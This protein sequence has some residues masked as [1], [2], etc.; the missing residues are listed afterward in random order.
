EV[1]ASAGAHRLAGVFSPIIPRNST[2][3]VSRTEIYAT[4]SDGQRGVDI[5]VY[6]GES[7]LGRDNVYPD[8]Y[9]GAGVPPGAAGAEKVAVTFTYDINGILKVST[10]VVS[11]GKEAHLLVDKS[12]ARL[13]DD[14]RAAAKARLD[15]EWGTSAAA[16]PAPP[17]PAAAAP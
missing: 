1:Q 6:Q 15:R 16:S 10:K 8:Q 4:T 17:G 5:K 2:V 13:S 9:S 11:T 3:P 14:E 12:P 7:R